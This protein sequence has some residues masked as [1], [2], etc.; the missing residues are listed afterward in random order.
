[1]TQFVLNTVTDSNQ[2]AHDLVLTLQV[3]SLPD[4]IELEVAHVSNGV[5]NVDWLATLPIRAIETMHGAL[6]VFLPNVDSDFLE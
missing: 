1:M 5:K 4:H 6:G 2:V 3:S